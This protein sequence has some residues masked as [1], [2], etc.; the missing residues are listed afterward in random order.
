MEHHENLLQEDPKYYNKMKQ[1]ERAT[2]SFI[3]NPEKAVTGVITIPV[4]VHVVYNTTA[5]NVSNAQITSQMTVLT[6]DFRRLNSDANNTWP[7]AADSEIE[8]CLATVDPNGNPTTGITRTSSSNTSF[9]LNDQVKF[10]SSGGKDAWPAADYLNIWV[11]DL[12]SGYLGYAQFPGGPANTDGVVVDYEA[13]GTNGSAQA[14]FNL[15]R[16]GTHEVGHW[17]NLRHIWGDGNCNVDDFVND[18]PKS[19]DAN[20]GC[21]SGHVSCSTTD[22]VENYMD[23]SDDACMNL[24]TS[25]QKDRMRALFDTGGARESLLNSSA[26]GTANPPTCSDGQQNGN[27]TGV[28]CGGPD[29]PACPSCNGTEVTMT[30][31]LDNYPEETSWTLVDANGNTVASAGPYSGVPA[32]S[33]VTETWCLPNGCYDYTINDSYGDGICCAYGNGSY[34][35]TDENN[36]VLASGGAF[37]NSE[38]TNFCLGSTAPTCSDGIQNGNETGVDCGGPDCPPCSTCNG[39][40]VTM[41]IVLDD[42]PG[43]TSWEL[44]DANGNTVASG[45]PYS[46]MP[47]GGTVTESWCLADACF[48][49][50]IFDSY[51]DGICCAYGNGSYTLTDEN[52]NV[53][54][55]GGSFGSSETTNFCLGSTGPTCSDGIQ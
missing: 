4:V 23:Y 55:S 2:Q 29:C 31:V 8:F 35:L 45:G 1:I 50:T 41:T 7:Q 24:Y 5:E 46:N 43:E 40:D 9:N 10:N 52:N 36:N 22:M 11:C 49:Y 17:L 19:D 16:T 32:G 13:F 48:D 54:A 47:A 42:Y 51:G 14:P 33:T 20:Y 15:G 6:D 27:E 34:T 39:T 53:L 28:D 26:C 30:I 38:T 21:A 3:E 37:G 44:V 18:T 25:G 12:E